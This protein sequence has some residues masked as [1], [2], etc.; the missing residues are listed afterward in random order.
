MVTNMKQPLMP[1]RGPAG[2]VECRGALSMG[3]RFNRL[4]LDVAIWRGLLVLGEPVRRVLGLIFFLLRSCWTLLGDSKRVLWQALGWLSA[5]P[6]TP[7]LRN[8]GYNLVA[9]RRWHYALGELVSASRWLCGCRQAAS[10]LWQLTLA[11]FC[12]QPVSS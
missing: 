3:D 9:T 8:L 2:R 5:P 10:A 12:L 7:A 6:R 11:H 1:L 4:L